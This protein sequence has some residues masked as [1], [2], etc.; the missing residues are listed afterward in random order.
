MSR[1]R[2]FTAN[3]LMM[4]LLMIVIMTGIV[5]R[6][7]SSARERARTLSCG[8]NV[9]QLVVA[10]RMYGADNEGRF[11]TAPKGWD[12]L[13]P[14]AKNRQ[15]FMCPS[16]PAK[17]EPWTPSDVEN[18]WDYPG[19]TQGKGPGEAFNSDYILNP[20]LRTDDLPSQILVGDDSPWRHQR[21]WNGARLDG[22][23]ARWP[24]SEYEKMLGWVTKDEQP[25]R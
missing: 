25:K 11:P 18:P 21:G 10:L 8:S 16:A 22:A 3:E 5:A 15:I 2:A 19:P 9:K 24:A 14:Y 6:F 17:D 23:V 4:A 1:R 7:M 12:A 20:T 13:M